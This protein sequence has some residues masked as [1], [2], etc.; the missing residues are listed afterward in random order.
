LAAF[1]LTP[2]QDQE[3]AGALMWVPGGLLHALVAIV[4][5]APQLR[6]TTEAAD[7]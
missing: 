6:S 4:L 2:A 7:A 3:L 5:I 1:G